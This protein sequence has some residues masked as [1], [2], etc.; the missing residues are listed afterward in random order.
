MTTWLSRW[1]RILAIAVRRVRR[2]AEAGMTTAEYAVGTMAPEG[3][4]TWGSTCCDTLP[5]GVPQRAPPP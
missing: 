4:T 1:G 2:G 3:L 5:S